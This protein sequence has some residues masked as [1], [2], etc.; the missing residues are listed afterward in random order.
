MLGFGASCRC[1]ALDASRWNGGGGGGESPPKPLG[2]VCR[3]PLR[4]A[5][6]SGRARA[7]SPSAKQSTPQP[8][9][10][11]PAQPRPGR[12]ELRL[13]LF[14]FTS[15]LVAAAHQ[16]C[17]EFMEAPSS[18]FSPFSPPCWALLGV[19]VLTCF[20][21]HHLVRV[22]P[23]RKSSPAGPRRSGRLGGRAFGRESK[24]RGRKRGGKRG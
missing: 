3:Y 13:R 15:G 12:D 1:A 16:L 9:I 21:A 19:G 14:R 6:L 4:A 8:A 2:L 17:R 18:L 11:T 22:M 24:S 5:S 23:G 7:P 20:G 10:E